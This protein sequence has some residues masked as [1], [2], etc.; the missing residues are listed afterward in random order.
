MELQN[1]EHMKVCLRKTEFMLVITIFLTNQNYIRFP[2]IFKKSESHS[3][4]LA[5]GFY[6]SL[7][8]S[9]ADIRN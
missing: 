6:F 5:L 4:T 1:V 7:Y 3:I 2:A 9:Q 8:N